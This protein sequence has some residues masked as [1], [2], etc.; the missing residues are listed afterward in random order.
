M[1]LNERELFDAYRARPTQDGL[2]EVLRASQNTVYNLCF[3]VLRQAQ[4]AEDASQKVFLRI[5]DALPRIADGEH[6]RRLLSRASLQ[7]ALH[8]IESR[9]TRKAHEM[10][11]AQGTAQ[12][13]PGTPDDASSLLLTH[14]A[15]LDDNLRCLVVDH[16][17]EGKP[18]EAMASERG[19]SR[20]AIWKG[21][22]KAKER[23]RLSL[24]GAGLT[25]LA[26]EM[27]S[28]LEAVVFAPAPRNLVGE[29]IA[30]KVAALSTPGAAG[31]GGW[32]RAGAHGKSGIAI[33][34]LSTAVLLAGALGILLRPTSESPTPPR[35]IRQ[36]KPPARAEARSS[37]GSPTASARLPSAAAGGPNPAKAPRPYPFALPRPT[38]NPAVQAAWNALRTP[39]TVERENF[40][41]V[42]IIKLVAQHAGLAFRLD[43][44]LKVLEH[45]ITYKV[46]EVSIDSA[47][48]FLL[49]TKDLAYALQE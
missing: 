21:L 48:Q 20:V 3:H 8:T 26:L 27:Q 37:S 49:S 41:L 45:P 32:I 24:S 36:D 43:P 42:Q 44:E 47:L 13:S 28:S 25:A 29:A 40:P 9:K 35:A 18:M 15:T 7:V 38:W 16:Y 1:A 2:L 14:V 17:F 34:G 33:G 11:K 46:K 30:A 5:L 10:N 31:W 22:E 23:L 39:I 4:D 12:A 6:Y 19:C